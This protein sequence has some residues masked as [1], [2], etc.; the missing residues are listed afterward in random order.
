VLFGGDAGHGLEEVGEVGSALFDGPVL[1]GRRDGIGGVGVEGRALADGL[2]EGLEDG[3][4]EALALDFFVEDVDAEEVF[5]VGLLEVDAVQLVPGGGDGHDGRLAK[6][7]R[8]HR[9]SSC[10]RGKN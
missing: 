1:H 4:G 7:R 2:L 8:T 3:L 6:V 5:D 10:E 9:G